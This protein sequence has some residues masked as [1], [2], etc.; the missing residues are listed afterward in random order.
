MA[1]VEDSIDELYAYYQAVAHYQLEPR[2]VRASAV[3][4]REAIPWLEELGVI[5]YARDLYKAGLDSQ[6]IHEGISRKEI[7][8]D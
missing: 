6:P 7:L 8:V 2:L 5:F 4:T 1:G 3:G